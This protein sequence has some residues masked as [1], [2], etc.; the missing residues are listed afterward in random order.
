MFSDFYTMQVAIKTELCLGKGKHTEPL[1]TCHS[2]V[3]S[4]GSWH[5]SS[6]ACVPDL[7]PR[8][9]LSTPRN[10]ARVPDYFCS[11]FAPDPDCPHA[12]ASPLC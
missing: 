4:M 1:R 6:E 11:G 12:Q 3:S 2:V 8:A 7:S 10:S 9:P 5:S